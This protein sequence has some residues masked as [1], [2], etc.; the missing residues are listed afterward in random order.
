MAF[1]RRRAAGND[2]VGSDGD[3]G[4]VQGNAVARKLA[5]LC[6]GEL[7]EFIRFSASAEYFCE[8]SA[9]AATARAVV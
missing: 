3:G 1:V 8:R 4:V 5:D 9:R 7:N 2:D 6:R